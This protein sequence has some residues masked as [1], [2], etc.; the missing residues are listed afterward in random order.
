[1][2]ADARGENKCI[3]SVE[4]GGERSQLAT[5]A[6]DKQV[7]RLGG[8][9]LVARQ[10]C[11]HVVAEAGNAKQ[12]RRLIKQVADG[13][14]RHFLLFHQIEHDAGVEAA[15]APAHDQ[16]VKGGESHRGRDALALLHGAHAGAAAEMGDHHA[17]LRDRQADNMRQYTGDVFVGQTME[18]VTADSLFA[19]TPR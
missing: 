16:P 1:M 18:P 11:L 2:L 19:Q 5:D 3:E 8:I 6:V 15:T 13:G 7:D 4:C 14:G 17:S 10:Q 12:P 9:W